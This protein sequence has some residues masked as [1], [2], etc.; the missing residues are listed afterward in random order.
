M[1]ITALI[2]SLFLI[3][4]V[5]GQKKTLSPEVYNDWKSLKSEEISANGEYVSYEINPHRGDG[6]LYVYNTKTNRTD[7]FPRGKEAQFSP[8]SNY[9]IFT[10]KPGLDTLRSVELKKIDKKKWPKDTLA[11]YLLKEDTLLTFTNYKSYTTSKENEWLAILFDHNNLSNPP[12]QKRPLCKKKREAMEYKT[13]GHV[14]QV[15]NYEGGKLERKYE[16]KDV[17]NIELSEYGTYMAFTVHQKKK[18]DSIYLN[19]LYTKDLNEISVENARTS[20]EK[21]TFNHQENQL[22]YLSS[23]DTSAK[24]RNYQLEMYSFD[25]HSIRILADTT[26][27]VI[28]EGNAVSI[29]YSPKFTKDGKYLYFGIAEKVKPEPKDSLTNDE[30]VHLDLWHWQDNNLQP[31]Q[32]KQ[33]KRDEKKTSLYVC[34]MK[35]MRLVKLA[36]DTLNVSTGYDLKGDYLIATSREKYSTYDNW[37]LP[38]A[39][40]YYRVNIQTGEASMIKDSALLLVDLSPSGNH[41]VYFENEEYYHKDLISNETS[42]ITCKEEK[43]IWTVDMN[44]QPMI[45]YPE[46]V[47]G[48]TN[49]ESVVFSSRYDVWSYDPSIKELHCISNYVGA[50]NKVKITPYLYEKDS[51]YLDIDNLYFTGLDEETKGTHLYELQKSEK[52]LN[53]VETANF[54]A[55]IYNISRSKNKMTYTFRKM[56]LKDYP[57]LHIHYGNYQDSKQITFSNPQQSDFNWATVELV[58]WKAY[59]GIELEGL[60]YK[61]EDFDPAKKYPL[62]VYYYELRSESLHQYYSPKPTASIIY[63]TEYASAGYVVFI[64]NIR[65]EPGHPAKSAYNCIMSGTDHVLNLYSNIDSTR[66]GLQGQSWGGYQTAQLVTMTKRYAAAMAGAPVTNMF[67]AYGGIRWGSGLNRQFQYEKAQSRIGATIWEAPELYIENSPQFHLPNVTT[68]LLIMHNDGDGAVP[69][70]QGIELFT[71]LKRLNKPVW[72]LNYND[73]EHNLMRNANR[74]DLSIR[75]RAFFDYYL[76][77]EDA[78]EWLIDGIPALEKGKEMRY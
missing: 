32:L 5:F 43:A 22:V 29:K 60:L 10:I 36:D 58:K 46:G 61:P 62:L 41:L 67:S 49:N 30:K 75:M 64:P 59:D 8:N 77:G 26:S 55:K 11:V 52:G 15:F 17:R 53:F 69:W 72:M 1:K 7:S 38:W 9:L 18:A 45:A 57:D 24:A 6:F 73:E 48:W 14:V 33:L 34:Q 42:C 13:T 56:T 23:A 47:L 71:G 20:I 70:Y 51:V 28:Q 19:I 74:M 35:D 3:S 44:G 16:H 39:S 37:S 27:S 63:P 68:P 78:P 76:L 54:D 50:N 65:Y 2:L 25:E 4:T 31:R 40:D 66:M 21:L 12:K